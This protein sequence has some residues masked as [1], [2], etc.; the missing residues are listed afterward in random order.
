MRFL[1]IINAAVQAY[2]ASGNEKS[3]MV[4]YTDMVNKVSNTGPG[5]LPRYLPSQ[6]TGFCRKCGARLVKDTIPAALS[7]GP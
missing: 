7:R 1:I 6:Q 4:N 5:M 3:R 2:H